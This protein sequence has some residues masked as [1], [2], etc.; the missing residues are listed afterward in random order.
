MIWIARAVLQP[1]I[2]ASTRQSVAY[3][4]TASLDVIITIAT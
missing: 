2:T 1:M 3:A 4:T